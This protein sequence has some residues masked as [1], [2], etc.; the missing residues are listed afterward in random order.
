MKGS[1]CERV[2]VVQ[3]FIE[4]L[5]RFHVVNHGD[6]VP[7]DIGLISAGLIPALVLQNLGDERH[8]VI[9]PACAN[10]AGIKK[11]LILCSKL[12]GKIRHGVFSFNLSFKIEE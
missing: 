11:V 6:Y 7:G 5:G 8:N 2:A 4:V 3:M 1:A 12:C 10:H 9:L